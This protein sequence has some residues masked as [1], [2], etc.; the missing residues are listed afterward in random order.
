MPNVLILGGSGLLGSAVSQA[1]LRTGLHT[2]FAQTRSTSK[3]LTL[4]ASEVAPLV[5]PLSDAEALTA[6]LQDND[7]DVVIDASQGYAETSAILSAIIAFSAARQAALKA[8]NAVGPKLGFVYTSG[9]MVHG[10]PSKFVSDLS[11]VGNSLASAPPA[12][13]VGWR[14]AV[15]QAILAARE[16]LDVVIM[17]PGMLYGRSAW[18]FGPFW[19]PVAAAKAMGAEAVKV[20]A[21]KEARFGLVHVDD[22]AESYTK[23][24][25]KIDNV[26]NWPIFDVVTENINLAA[27]LEET[28]RSL[29]LTANV[30]FEGTGG[31]VLMEA[32]GL[33]ANGSA[34]RARSVLGWEARRR[35][36]LLNVGGYYRAWEAAQGMENR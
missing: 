5:F 6:A 7:I 25:S 19:G 21:G 3:V 9:I 30:E 10:T 20:K 33:R 1:L 4:Q 22:A 28:I 16:H 8:E 15:E 29:G 35:D 27:I 2:V 32:L 11:P 34:S 36:F 23:A 31:D 24:V 13:M 18:N 14:P 17:R 12:N 26:G